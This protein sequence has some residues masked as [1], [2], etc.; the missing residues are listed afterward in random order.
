VKSICVGV[1][2][3]A[4]IFVEEAILEEHFGPDVT[5]KIVEAFEES[6]PAYVSRGILDV[7]FE[8]FGNPPDALDD[9][10]KVYIFYTHIAS[11][12]SMGFDGYFNAF[13]QMPDK[14]A[15]EKYRQH[16][17]EVEMIYMN[18][19]GSTKPD[20][21]YMLSVLAH[22]FQHLI[23]YNY[24]TE[25]ETWVNEAMSEAAMTVCGYFTDVAH[26][27]S[28][29]SNPSYPLI[30]ARISYGAVLLFGTYLLEQFGTDFLRELVASEKIGIAGVEAVLKDGGSFSDLFHRWGLANLC[31]GHLSVAEGPF[32][33]SSFPVP[34]VALSSEYLCG[35]LSIDFSL[36]SSGL[37]YVKVAAGEKP[38]SLRIDK[39]DVLNSR[40]SSLP[41]LSAGQRLPRVFFADTNGSSPVELK[42]VDGSGRLPSTGG[43]LMF[44]TI[45]CGSLI[46]TATISD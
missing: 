32:G 11:Y 27:G 25:E 6:C 31:A 44:S 12:G 4:Y 24:D 13:N 16:S 5:A 21:E 18:G 36:Q 29:C 23:H 14:V 1:T 3:H 30:K 17:N 45:D 26:L 37:A 22:E 7:E 8:V 40:E 28:Y 33:Y 41:G 2:D 39:A 38:L 43:F 9:D 34:Q 35:E 15:W 10:E 46:F 19:T 42:I 20:S